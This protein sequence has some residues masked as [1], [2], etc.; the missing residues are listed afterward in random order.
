MLFKFLIIFFSLGKFVVFPTTEVLSASFLSNTKILLVSSS[1]EKLAMSLSEYS[2]WTR[3]D[4]I[5][6][7]LDESFLFLLGFMIYFWYK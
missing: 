6:L 2:D 5:D 3:C 7:D 4:C 1:I